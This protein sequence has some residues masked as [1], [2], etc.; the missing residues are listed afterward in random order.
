MFSHPVFLRKVSLC[1]QKKQQAKNLIGINM[2]SPIQSRGS[3][4]WFVVSGG[5]ISIFSSLTFASSVFVL[6]LDELRLN[7]LQIG[8][9]LSLMPFCGVLSLV[10]APLL[11]RMGLK[12]AFLVFYGARK[13]VMLAIILL[14]PVVV[15]HGGASIGF[16]Y[17]VGLMLVF[18]VCRSLAETAYLPW[19]QEVV[20][21]ASRGQFDAISNGVS[22]ALIL[23][24]MSCASVYLARGSGLDRFMVIMSLG[25]GLGLLGVFVAGLIL[26]GTPAPAMSL[27]VYGQAL[28]DVLFDKR[29]ALFLAGQSLIVAVIAV[30]QTF[31]PL[32][33]KQVVG[34]S[35]SRILWIDIGTA[36]AVILCSYGWGWVADR[37]GSKPTA[38]TAILLMGLVPIGWIGVPHV[39]LSLRQTA[40]IIIAV[41]W[42]LSFSGVLVGVSRLLNV[43]LV[44]KDRRIAS[45]SLYY[46]A[47]GL[48]GGLGTLF[49]GWFLNATAHFHFIPG[50]NSAD[51]YILLWILCLLFIGAGGIIIG[52]IHP[53]KE[54][55]FR[56]FWRYVVGRVWPS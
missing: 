44:A 27:R 54:M 18:A 32:Y 48:A 33:A 28:R 23:L 3:Y 37:F 14:A 24:A 5:L 12:R 51:H 46:A 2:N 13:I 11:A 55:G 39:M 45:M 52:R 22:S 36:G 53:G 26:G 7:K 35:I 17:V 49:G 25:V 50:S 47:S 38:L 31:I 30:I 40:V 43:N 4:K 42:G 10:T 6:F 56:V 16:L 34:I 15:E 9:I 41:L 19:S 29:F 20:P 1:S 8:T 21:S